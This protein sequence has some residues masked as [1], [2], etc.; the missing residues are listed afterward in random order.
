MKYM[1]TPITEATIKKRKEIRSVYSSEAG[2]KEI[3]NLFH[4]AGLF[5]VVQE[6]ELDA[7]NRAILKAEELGLLDEG[8]IRYLI[9]YLLTSGILEKMENERLKK[10]DDGL[11]SVHQLHI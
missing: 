7:R 6:R 8:V 3:F 4:D 10:V 11:M 1:K 9:E 2:Q 5:R